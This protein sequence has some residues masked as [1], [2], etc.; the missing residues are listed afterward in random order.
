[1]KRVS[2]FQRPLVSF[3]ASRPLTF[4]VLP[5]V[6]WALPKGRFLF[7]GRTSEGKHGHARFEGPILPSDI[8]YRFPADWIRY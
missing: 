2:N 1:M 6:T 5:E 7:L 8:F 4:F 3:L